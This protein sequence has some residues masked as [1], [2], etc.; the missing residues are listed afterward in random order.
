M[1][2]QVK[3]CATFCQLPGGSAGSLHNSPHSPSK[4]QPCDLEAFRSAFSGVVFRFKTEES[5]LFMTARGLRNSKTVALTKFQK[6]LKY[7]KTMQD[8]FMYT[9]NLISEAWFVPLRGGGGGGVV[10]TL[11]PHVRILFCVEEMCCRL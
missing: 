11:Q 6:A 9:N 4:R 10:A 2:I 7:H 8:K 3:D 5:S 1:A